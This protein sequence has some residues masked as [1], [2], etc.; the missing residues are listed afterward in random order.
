MDLQLKD[1]RIL[2]T[3]ASSGIGLATATM[4]AGEGARLALCARDED[5]LR[6]ATSELAASTDVFT[7]SCDVTDRQSVENFVSHAVDSLGG[8]DGLVCNAGRSLMSTIDQT[9][10]DQIREE[11]D[12]KIFG[13][14][15]VVRAAKKALASS[16]SGRSSSSTRSSP[17]SRN[18][19]WRSPP[20]RGPVCS[21]FPVH[22]RRIWLRTTSASIPSCSVWSTPDSG[23]AATPT[24]TPR[25]ISTSGAPRSLRIEASDS[26]ASA[27]RTNSLS[28]SPR[29]SR[30]SAATSPA[31]PRR[32]RRRPPLRL[33]TRTFSGERHDRR[34]SRPTHGR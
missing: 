34:S 33:A 31:H 32:R 25:S 29:S 13:A 14:L 15:N 18:R 28:P 10:D 9:T 20:P 23:S 1:R 27:P 12:L 26:D 8:L 2:I 7:F 30:R 11:F 22:S 3:G 6:E 5:R 16:D 17:D 19:G 4:L 24:A 21:T